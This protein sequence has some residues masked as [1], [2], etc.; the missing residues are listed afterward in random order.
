MECTLTGRGLQITP[1][2]RE[3]IDRRLHPLERVLGDALVSADMVLSSAHGQCSSE[4]VFHAK[5]DHRLHGLAEGDNW[6]ASVGATVDKVLHQAHT[7]KG[8][9]QA[10][11]RQSPPAPPDAPTS[12]GPARST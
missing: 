2:L 8:K 12:S 5:G 11:R 1:E 6:H 3:L 4:L 10:R 9:W 7:L